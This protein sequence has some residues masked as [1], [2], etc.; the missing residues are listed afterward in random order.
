MLFQIRLTRLSI[1]FN[2]WQCKCLN[3]LL[4]WAQKNDIAYMS[5]SFN[6]ER[7]VCVAVPSDK[8]GCVRDQDWVNQNNIVPLFEMAISE[9]ENKLAEGTTASNILMGN[10]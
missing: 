9:Y 4:I 3:D 8:K 10:V 2:P 7:P 5:T 6:G 1:G